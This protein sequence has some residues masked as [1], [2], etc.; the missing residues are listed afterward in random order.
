MPNCVAFG[1]EF[2]NE[3]NSI[4]E[5]NESISIDSL[6]KATEIYA[7]ALYSLIKAE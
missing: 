1:P 6:L 3:N 7:K 4:H 2:P 5:N